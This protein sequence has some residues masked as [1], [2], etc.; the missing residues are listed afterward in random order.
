MSKK[1][2]EMFEVTDG[3]SID[4]CLDRMKEAGYLPIKRIE[5]PIF[6][7]KV[8]DGKVE[9]EPVQ[10]KIVFEGKLIE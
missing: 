5:K 10:R 4:E 3:E 2:K 9:Y 8:K 1:K 7:E 6:E